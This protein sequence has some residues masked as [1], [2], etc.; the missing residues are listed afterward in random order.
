MILNSDLCIDEKSA[1][2]FIV[3]PKEDKVH[4][5]WEVDGQIIFFERIPINYPSSSLMIS[6]NFNEYLNAIWEV[7]WINENNIVRIDK[8]FDFKDTL[9]KE[10]NF[11]NK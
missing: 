3:E 10:N 7:N 6:E 4:I 1:L 9:R 8:R 2:L 5:S 11:V